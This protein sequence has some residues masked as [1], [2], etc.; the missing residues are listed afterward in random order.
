MALFIS[1]HDNP[2]EQLKT[3]IQSAYLTIPEHWERRLPPMMAICAGRPLRGILDFQSETVRRERAHRQFRH[4]LGDHSPLKDEEP[5]VM[6]GLVG[7]DEY[8]AY[9]TTVVNDGGEVSNETVKI[10]FLRECAIALLH[11][12]SFWSHVP[13]SYQEDRERLTCLYLSMLY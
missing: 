2:P 10:R 7:V 5:F 8:L 1:T 11:E 12:P 6:F 9:V 13:K 4:I 3:L